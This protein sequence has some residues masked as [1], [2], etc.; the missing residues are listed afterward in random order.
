MEILA[1][2]LISLGIWAFTPNKVYYNTQYD[3]SAVAQDANK[4]CGSAGYLV[5]R[6]GFVNAK[7]DV[8]Y[9]KCKDS[10]WSAN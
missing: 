9:F 8:Q 4:A 7:G 6:S 10:S 1:M 5:Y 3:P 2:G